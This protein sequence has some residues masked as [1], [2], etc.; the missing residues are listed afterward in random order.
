MLTKPKIMNARFVRPED[1]GAIER[2]QRASKNGAVTVMPETPEVK[3]FMK[4][5]AKLRSMDT[6]IKF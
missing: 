6:T 2:V 5:R 4:M 3:L 1:E